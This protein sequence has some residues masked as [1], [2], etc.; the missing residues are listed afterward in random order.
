MPRRGLLLS[1]SIELAGS[2]TMLKMLTTKSK[3]QFTLKLHN[4]ITYTTLN[5]KILC[6][7]CNTNIWW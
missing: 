6:I 5:Q 1:R 2:N 3:N 4:Y 7:S